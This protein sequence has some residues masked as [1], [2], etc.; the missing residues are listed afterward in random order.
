MV[1]VHTVSP[2]QTETWLKEQ[3]EKGETKKAELIKNPRV[4]LDIAMDGTPLGRVVV[5]LD[6]ENAPVTCANFL[7]LATG[8]HAKTDKRLSYKGNIFHRIVPN[9]YLCGG[10]VI[11]NNG[12]SGL[13]I[14]GETFPDEKTGLKHDVPG[15]LSMLGHG[16]NTNSSQ[17]FVTLTPAP[18]MD[19]YY[20][21]FGKVVSGLDLLSMISEACG[22]E[23]GVPKS[24]DVRIVACGQLN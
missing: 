19:D 8:S 20:V 13:S 22:T 12:T 17:F 15:V 1:L 5:E 6:M 10:D 7:A 14:Y 3:A 9:V 4:F 11:N 23:S 21:A 18:W 2:A 16:P 24:D